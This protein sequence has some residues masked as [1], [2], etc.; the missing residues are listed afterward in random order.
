MTPFRDVALTTW[1]PALFKYA[2]CLWC[3][4]ALLIY[5]SY[6]HLSM[7]WK[8][9]RK[10]VINETAHHSTSQQVCIGVREL[11]PRGRHPSHEEEATHY[12]QTKKD[13]GTAL[14]ASLT[15]RFKA[16]HPPAPL[17]TR[18]YCRSLRSTSADALQSVSISVRSAPPLSVA[19]V[20]A[21]G[22]FVNISEQ[23]K[24][25]DRYIGALKASL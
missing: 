19:E 23:M 10:L 24:R 11:R 1:L 14:T 13:S 7:M 16:Y 2:L 25:I 5:R 8:S 18:R 15:L 21:H 3:C 12:R 17:P 4:Q 6:Q 20:V 9:S 22:L